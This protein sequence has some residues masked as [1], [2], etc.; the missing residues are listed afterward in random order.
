M[1]QHIVL[2]RLKETDPATRDKTIRQIKIR[3]ESLQT[4]IQQIKKIV[5][6]GNVLSGDHA[7]DVALV[8]EF[9]SLEDLQIYQTHPEHQ[10]FHTNR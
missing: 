8:S 2:W 7:S 1:I 6:G 9:T 4:K 3:L 10:P 5:V